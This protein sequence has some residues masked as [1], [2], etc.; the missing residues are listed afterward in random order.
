MIYVYGFYISV[1]VN[2][3]SI[4]SLLAWMLLTL[5]LFLGLSLLDV[6]LFT[7]LLPLHQQMRTSP[8]ICST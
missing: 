6:T 5:T 1:D 2:S 8:I 7:P 4:S 3:D